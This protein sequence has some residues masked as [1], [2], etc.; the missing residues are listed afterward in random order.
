[1][2]LKDKAS[3]VS[4]S[5]IQSQADSATATAKKTSGDAELSTA[6]VEQNKTG[7][8]QFAFRRVPNLSY[9]AV[10]KLSPFSHTPRFN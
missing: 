7:D 9:H 4:K 5:A 8:R 3:L 2:K 10:S 6:L 1:M